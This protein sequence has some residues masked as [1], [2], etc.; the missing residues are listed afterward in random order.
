[1][2]LRTF[3]FLDAAAVDENLAAMEGL[4][5]DGPVSE[6][7]RG[8]RDG[9]VNVGVG[10]IGVGGS[11]GSD[12]ETVRQYRSTPEGRFQRLIDLLDRDDELQRLE[13]FDDKIWEQLRRSEALEVVG[14][15]R[16]PDMFRVSDVSQQAGKL[17]AFI[18]SIGL[19]AGMDT[20]ARQGLTAMQQIGEVLEDQR[21]PIILNAS[22]QREY[23][24]IGHLN[25][26]H[27]RV[28]PSQIQG[29]ISIFGTV[30][31]KVQTGERY[32][33]FNLVPDMEE[34]PSL[35]RNQRRSAAKNSKPKSASGAAE[36]VKGPAIVMNVLAVYQ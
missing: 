6:T 17:L 10:P 11:K 34:F 3:L 23:P 36:E 33:I 26:E 31:R 28:T 22:G 7:Q 19:D 4:L 27:L 1:M 29:E 16:V 30:Q 18:E 32:Q 8:H 20:E 9:G 2:P 15:I 35:N 13:A 5:D 12:F 24:F 14:A 25:R 21:V